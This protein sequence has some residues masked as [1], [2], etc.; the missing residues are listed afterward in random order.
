MLWTFEES[1]GEAIMKTAQDLVLNEFIP[2]GRCIEINV[3]RNVRRTRDI[4]VRKRAEEASS[5]SHRPLPSTV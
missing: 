1:Y 4:V 5:H 2:E 3:G